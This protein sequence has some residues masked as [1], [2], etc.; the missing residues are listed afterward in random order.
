MN[1]KTI[2]TVVLFGLGIILF[3]CSNTSEKQADDRPLLL[4]LEKDFLNKEFSLDTS[5]LSS[6]IDSTYV[7][8]TEHGIKNKRETLISIYHNIDL[9]IK[10]G[11]VI[12]SFRFENE[13]V[14][15]YSNTAVVT[16][17]VHSFRHSGDSIIERRTRFYDVWTRRNENWKLVASQGTV[18]QNPD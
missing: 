7:D 9:R 2:Q 5:A 15:V 6:L 18:I 13:I 10:N 11:I 1:A 16:F 3:Q 4:T 8:I 12:D 14:N 17:I